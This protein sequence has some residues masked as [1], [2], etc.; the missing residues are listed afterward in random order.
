MKGAKVIDINTVAISNNAILRKDDKYGIDI[1]VKKTSKLMGDELK[2]SGDF[3]I[4]GHLAPYVLNPARI[5]L[6][7][8]LR[9]SPYELTK[10][11]KQRKYPP[12]KIRE[13]VA[14]E[15]LG[16]SLYDALKTFGKR[17]ITEIDTTAK[18]PQHIADEIILLLQKKKRKQVAGI[19]DWLSLIY[20]RGDIQ[21]FLEY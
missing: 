2:T 14:S 13:N 4:I 10:T 19:V 18:M 17:K 7:T 21:K 3:V 6:V 16:V 9:R 15:I 5:D 1:D 12:D 11:F 20:E 8:V